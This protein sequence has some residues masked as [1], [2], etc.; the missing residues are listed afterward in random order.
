MDD[1]DGCVGK[2]VKGHLS[3]SFSGLLSHH[4]HVTSLTSVFSVCVY[5]CNFS[6]VSVPVASV[7]NRSCVMGMFQRSTPAH[8][9]QN[10]HVEDRLAGSGSRKHLECLCGIQ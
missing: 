7:E 2:S 8:T 5:V 3:L 9:P 6:L 4:P 10:S 1:P